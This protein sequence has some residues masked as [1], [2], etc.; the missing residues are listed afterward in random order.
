MADKVNVKKNT[1]FNMIKS[2]A[3]IVFPM[4]SFPYASRVLLADSLGK[5]NFANSVVSFFNLLAGLGIATYAIRECSR[6]RENKKELESV[7]SQ[8]YTIN[9]YTTVVAYMCLLM[10]LLVARP[11]EKYRTLILLLSV[12]IG[13][14]TIG[15][16]WINNV[17]EDF[18]FIT[19]RT[20]A[21][22][23]LSVV[24]LILL[25]KSPE[26]YLMYAGITV[27]SNGGANLL[28]AIYRKKYCKL[29]FVKNIDWRKHFPPI[30]LLF[31]M[32]IAQTIYVNSDTTILGLVKGDYAVGLYSVP[33][34]IY[35]IVQTLVNSVTYAVLPQLSYW[36][37]RKNYEKLNPILRYG[38]SF[39]VTLGLPCVVGIIAI[40]PELIILVAGKEYIEATLSLRILAL[41]LGASFCAG[42]LGNMIMIPSGRDRLCMVSS[43]VSAAAN[44]LLNIIFIPKWGINA[45]AA[46]T[47]LSQILGF[48]IKLPFVEKEI[49]IGNKKGLFLGPVA[50]SIEIFLVAYCVK[51]F[52]SNMMIKLFSIVFISVVLY[53]I[54]LVVTK[55]DLGLSVLESVKRKCY[56]NGK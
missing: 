39:T 43:C 13:L 16:D 52:V 11:L 44:F 10:T 8:L 29:H 53:G 9:I 32:L 25:V 35:N 46:T 41:A 15:A 19:I 38:L 27:L 18:K 3:A 51:L 34:K 12:T 23:A 4:I 42:F 33:V 47:L 21:F 48:L 6:V 50:G 28:N 5:V 24:L 2:V 22:Q 7:A 54:T 17:M 1:I 56:K 20:V 31:S 49:S 30:L 26:D 37:A 14:T 45:A 36:F 40:A 55:N